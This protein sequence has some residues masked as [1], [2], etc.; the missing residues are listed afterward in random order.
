MKAKWLVEL[1]MFLDTEERLIE[2]IKK[3][4][5]EVKTL[6]YIPFDDDLPSKC[7]KYYD[8]TECVVFYGSLGFG[9]KL[10]KNWTPGVYCN[11][12][13][14]DCT[15]YYPAF[16]EHLLNRDYIMMPY[17]DIKNKKDF[18]YKTFNSDKVFM[19]P[20][21]M[22]KQFTGQVV[23]KFNFDEAY[24][25]LG[26]YD[27][28]PSLLSVISSVKDIRKEW[29][30]VICNNEVISGSLYRDWDLY[31]SEVNLPCTD[32]SARKYADE[33]CKLYKP[34][35]VWTLDVC[36]LDTGEY[37][38]LEIGCFSCAG[39]YGNDLDIIVE[40]VSETAEKDWKGKIK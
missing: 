14:Y 33:L 5:R 35:S 4:G 19:R 11:Y 12:E 22:L 29:R 1:D 21:S 30:F 38:L 26:F 40:K 3:S 6:K 20:S 24:K 7:Y 13:K 28:E 8:P 25:V 9:T 18:I 37:R 2:A 15:N 39:M 32:D 34:E 36:L 16:S 17:G 10:R 23:S 31:K 27:V